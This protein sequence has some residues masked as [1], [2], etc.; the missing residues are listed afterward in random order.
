[1]FATTFSF[2]PVVCW[3]VNVITRIGYCLTQ[4]QIQYTC[5]NNHFAIFIAVRDI[6]TLSAPANGVCLV[7]DDNFFS[8][9][10]QFDRSI[11]VRS[12]Y[13]FTRVCGNDFRMRTHILFY[14]SFTAARFSRGF[15][16]RI[17]TPDRYRYD[18]THDCRCRCCIIIT[19]S[20]SQVSI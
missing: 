6:N 13:S 14:K 16:N 12:P 20:V 4:T 2:D 5:V 1:M 19:V 15:R 17:R 10:T 3:H 11:K 7:S 8:F 18:T 9:K